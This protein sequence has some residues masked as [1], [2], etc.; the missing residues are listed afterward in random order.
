MIQSLSICLMNMCVLFFF[1]KNKI[2][3]F[4]GVHVFTFVD[5]KYLT[6]CVTIDVALAVSKAVETFLDF[7]D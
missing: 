7:V 5:A 2:N 6:I 3:Y 4:L 1:E